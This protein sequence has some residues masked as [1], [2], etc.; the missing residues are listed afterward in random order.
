MTRNAWIIFAV[1]CAVLLGGLIW[2]SRGDRVD[3]SEVDPHVALEAS[4]ASGNIA[5]WTKGSQDPK[6]VIVEYADFQCPGCQNAAPVLNQVIAQYGEHVQLVYRHFPLSNIHP[7]A[8]AAAAA[9]EAAGKQGK[10]WEMHERLYTN[11]SDW[12]QAS[13]TARTNQFADYAVMLGV[14]R[15]Q[16]E[17]DIVNPEISK[18]I[19]FDAA[20]GRDIGVSSTPTIFVDGDQL[21]EWFVGDEIV[22]QGTEGARQVWTDAEAIGKLIIE[23]KLREAGVELT[24]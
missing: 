10:F 15:E 23:P 13:G 3:V 5:D 7:N 11:Q 9:A 12:A 16:F 22:P 2:A 8:R 14:D 4:E 18:K 21:D 20:I 17:Q 24:N 19:S 1:I 6:I